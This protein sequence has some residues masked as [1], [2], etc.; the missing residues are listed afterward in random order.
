MSPIPATAVRR[1]SPKLP[2]LVP[3]AEDRRILD[4]VDLY[5]G[6]GRDLLRY[7][8][9]VSAADRFGERFPLASTAHRPDASFGFFDQATVDGRPMPVMGNFQTMFY[10]QPKSPGRDRREAALWMREQMREFALRYFM[11][12]SDFRR[13]R[14]YVEERRSPPP[15]VFEPLS[16]CAR[17]S[18]SDVGF[19]FRQLFFRRPGGEIGVFPA[20]EQGA[21]VDLRRIGR[22]LDW[23]V[24]RVKI[25]DFAFGF[26]PFAG[27][28]SLSLPLDEDSFLVVSPEFVLAEDDPE[29]GELGHYGLGYAF[30]KN[31]EPGVLAYGP[32]EFDAAIELIDFHVFADG[33]VT[34]TAVFVANRPR[35]IVNFDP[36]G[37]G[38]AGV[39]ALSLGLAAPFLAPFEAAWRSLRPPALPDP[40][41]TSLALADLASF[42]WTS[43]ELCWSR[44][45]LDVEFLLKHFQQH[46]ET[47]AGS[48]QTWRQIPDWL[49]TA[50][51]PRWVVEGRSG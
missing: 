49:D 8:K 2:G 38:F 23:I 25:F 5:L 37:W 18:A 19:G 6:R 20:E 1:D 42:G 44:R 12:V 13:P 36:V 21:I 48:L 27:G 14:P 4:A 24:T 50:A 15:K 9:E 22:D 39:K 47:L 34:V 28:P 3:S 16:L 40:I 43:R 31:P 17:D 32:G 51:L 33:R 11:R 45:A 41:F 7:W 35:G 26:S 30:V 46:Y 29:P 10:D